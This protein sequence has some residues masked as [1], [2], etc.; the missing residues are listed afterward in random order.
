[1]GYIDS[2]S[3]SCRYRSKLW[4]VC[5]LGCTG[6]SCNYS[7]NNANEQF[8]WSSRRRC[9]IYF[10]S[11]R[12]FCIFIYFSCSPQLT[13][14]APTSTLTTPQMVPER[15]QKTSLGRTLTLSTWTTCWEAELQAPQV[16]TT[17][18]I[19]RLVLF[20]ATAL[21]LFVSSLLNSCS[22]L[23]GRSAADIKISW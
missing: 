15:L 3:T 11:F 8:V 20:C 5:F 19:F 13:H 22:H 6:S 18:F 9:K 16:S 2:C 10:Q 1:M 23:Y 14:W 21:C 7:I 17:K 4:S 12:R